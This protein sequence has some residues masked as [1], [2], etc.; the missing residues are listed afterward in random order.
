MAAMV[1]ESAKVV[2]E[3]IARRPMDVDVTLLYGYGF[4]RYRGGP[5]K[6]ADMV[7]L[8]NV[9]ADLREFEAEDSEFWKPAQ[10]LVDL[11][12]KGENFDSL[13]KSA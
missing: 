2:G 7:G 9:L 13:N 5:M 11:V 1:N 8:E 3:G 6:Y 4:P 12:A 10:L